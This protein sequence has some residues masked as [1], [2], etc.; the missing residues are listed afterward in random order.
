[1]SLPQHHP[2]LASLA[3]YAAGHLDAAAS[4]LVACHLT[5]CPRCR[6]TVAGLEALGGALVAAE[7]GQLGPLDVE[8]IL[9]DD[10]VAVPIPRP[11][12]PDGVLPAPLVAQVG[13]FSDLPWRW[14]SPGVQQ[15]RILE[16][17]GRLPL[18]LL[19]LRPGIRIPRHDHDADERALL[20]AGGW[21]DER[22]HFVRGDLSLVE[23][24]RRD[25]R[26][27]VDEGEP[28]VAL[29][30]NDAPIRPAVAW[31]RLAARLIGI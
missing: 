10:G 14:L 5:L 27:R 4:L 6:E 18:R 31:L 22:D 17:P 15:V 16:R 3:A 28:C 29:V 13:R 2:R 30:M 9:A 23:A 19:R 20:L 11:H 21:A 12:D 1:M 24:S 26:V 25:H 8:A 7:S